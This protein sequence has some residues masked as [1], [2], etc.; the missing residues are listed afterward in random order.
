MSKEMIDICPFYIEKIKRIFKR[1]GLPVDQE[2]CRQ[3]I[4]IIVKTILL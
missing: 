4:D 3:T 2:T 1:L